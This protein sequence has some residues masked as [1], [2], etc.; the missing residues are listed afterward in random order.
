M[1]FPQPNHPA[2]V[3][4]LLATLPDGIKV[5]QRIPRMRAC[6]E[7]KEKGKPCH[8]HIKRWYGF[9]AEVARLAGAPAAEVYRCERCHTIYLPNR[10]EPPRTGILSW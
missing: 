9:N 10:E 4:E 6:N 1:N 7:L 3:S 8:G 5:K 2:P